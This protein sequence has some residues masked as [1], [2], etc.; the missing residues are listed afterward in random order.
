V[1]IEIERAA[2]RSLRV[3][4][5][6]EEEKGDAKIVKGLRDTGIDVY[7][8]LKLDSGFFILAQ[9][10]VARSE[11][12]VRLQRMGIDLESFFEVQSGSAGVTRPARG[13]VRR[14]NLG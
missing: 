6:L 9:F 8:F 5:T 4:I 11:I 14:P 7:G 1:W 2:R 3:W 10:D 12:V 13:G